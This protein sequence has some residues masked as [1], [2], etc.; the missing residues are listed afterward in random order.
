MGKCNTHAARDVS[1][2]GVAN[3]M[4]IGAFSLRVAFKLNASVCHAAAQSNGQM[5]DGEGKNDDQTGG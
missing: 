5:P 4:R 3:M 2:Y 1:C